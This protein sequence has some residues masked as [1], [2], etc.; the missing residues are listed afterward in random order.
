MQLHDEY[1]EKA[2]ITL[3]LQNIA[4]F[5][6]IKGDLSVSRGRQS[7]AVV[8]KFDLQIKTYSGRDKENVLDERGGH[9]RKFSKYSKGMG[10]AH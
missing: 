6:F 2:K 9:H 3:N 1:P 10:G 7:N 8:E 4:S 5:P